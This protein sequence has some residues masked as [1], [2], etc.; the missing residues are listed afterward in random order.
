MGLCDRNEER[1]CAEKR[2]G[3]PVVEGRKGEDEGVHKGTVKEELHLT[4]EVITDS[5]SI[6]CGKEGWK[7]A[8][9]TRLLI[10]E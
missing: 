8:D 10:S 2:K 5:A 3:V 4:I 6:L 1:I 7:K 9:D